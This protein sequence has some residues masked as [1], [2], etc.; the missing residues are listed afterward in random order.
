MFVFPDRSVFVSCTE[1][2]SSPTQVYGDQWG[3]NM[4]N[5]G[6]KICQLTS[7]ASKLLGQ[8]HSGYCPQCFSTKYYNNVKIV[9]WNAW[10]RL[11]LWPWGLSEAPRNH[12]DLAKMEEM[13]GSCL[14]QVRE[15][16]MNSNQQCNFTNM[17]IGPRHTIFMYSWFPREH[18]ENPSLTKTTRIPKII[19]VLF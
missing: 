7:T 9:P 19:I 4:L 16:K 6:D 8:T 12:F 5:M 2:Y 14:V 3:D 1:R 11:E 10:L 13:G 17:G 18:V 15:G